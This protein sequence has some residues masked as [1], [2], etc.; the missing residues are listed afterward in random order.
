MILLLVEIGMVIAGILALMKGKFLVIG[1][2]VASGPASRIAGALL[3]LPMP[4]VL[5]TGFVIGW[6]CAQKR[7]PFKVEE[8]AF[9]AALIELLLVLGCLVLALGI[10]I[11][12]SRPPEPLRDA[13][14]GAEPDS[15]SPAC[16]DALDVLP[17][18]AP[19]VEPDAIQRTTTR[20][21]LPQ[22]VTA[23]IHERPL[24]PLIR[25]P[26]RSLLPWLVGGSVGF[27]LFVVVT[28]GLVI[29]WV[30][31]QLPTMQPT[32][33]QPTTLGGGPWSPPA[34]PPLDTASY[35][36]RLDILRAT[37]LEQKP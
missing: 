28:T 30:Q 4:L 5:G 15:D 22:A 18:D 14:F 20:F 34:G 1:D 9:E 35:K 17:V 13:R 10:A 8:W 37:S 21:P 16:E 7:I 36:A 6:V 11:A 33:V 12:H 2:R 26:R 29:L 32:Q 19:T 27:A 3:L 24:P 31:S 25:K 23:P